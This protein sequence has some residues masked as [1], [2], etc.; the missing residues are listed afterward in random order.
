MIWHA[1]TFRIALCMLR[2]TLWKH[3]VG[4]IKAVVKNENVEKNRDVWKHKAVEKNKSIEKNRS[5]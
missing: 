1:A 2:V 4:D 5:I 3:H